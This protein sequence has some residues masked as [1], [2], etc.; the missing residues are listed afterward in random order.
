MPYS[1]EIIVG[2]IDMKEEQDIQTNGKPGIE[3]PSDFSEKL[4]AAISKTQELVAQWKSANEG[5][6]LELNFPL[7][8]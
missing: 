3:L 8:K 7:Q 6:A 5:Q 4:Q 2:Y 1:A